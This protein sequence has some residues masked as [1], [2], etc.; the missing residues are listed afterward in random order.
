M[1]ENTLLT[2]IKL[3][4]DTLTNWN[5]SSLVLKA[6]EAAVAYITTAGNIAGSSNTNQANT[7]R[8]VGIKIGDG[9]HTLAQLPWVQAVAADVYDWAKASTKPTYDATEIQNLD[10]YISG[11]IQDTN[12]TYQI[13]AKTGANLGKWELQAKELGS[14]TWTTISTIDTTMYGADIAALQQK[15]GNDSVSDQIDAALGAL[16]VTDTAV[17]NQFVTAVSQTDGEISVSR[18]ALT[19]DAIPNLP[20]SK[21]T[22]GTLPVERGGTGASTLASGEV[23]VGN[24][25]GAITTKAIDSTIADSSTSTNLVTAAA[26]ASYVDSKTESLSGAMHF[27]GV[28]TTA[29][30]DG[31]TQ[32][33]TIDGSVVTE[34]TAGDVVLYNNQEFVWTGSAWELLGDEGSYA[35]KTVTITGTDG[36]T[37]GGAIS[38][39]QTISHAVPS[40]AAAETKGGSSGTRTYI[41][42][43]TTDKFGHVTAATTASETVTD[44]TYTF[45]EGTTNGAFS[46][47]PTGGTAQTVNVHGLGT[48]A[49]KAADSTVSA[50][51]T[52]VPT[53]AAVNTAISNLTNSLDPIAYDGEVKN[54][55]Q[56]DDTI[57]VF[58]CGTATTVV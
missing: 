16:N 2:R 22:S 34:K 58:D 54:L 7:P 49:Y 57:L 36:L 45:A 29:I 14:S 11:E 40:G 9:T 20:A 18:A 25:T 53:T 42:S 50:T 3:K 33:P 44:T 48:A 27:K 41:Q 35:L 47:T 51:G 4:Y 56:T 37:G 43:I 5:N 17:T 23:L 39:N 31:G 6:G 21:I 19:A 24:G 1:A 8:A 38:A 52:G 55:K 12:T 15:V 28:S 10:S 26:V 13:I 30:T 46:V 32:N